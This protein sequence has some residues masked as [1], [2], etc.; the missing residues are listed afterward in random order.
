MEQNSNMHNSTG[1]TSDKL[2]EQTLKADGNKPVSGHTENANQ[3]DNDEATDENQASASK[4][5][6][7]GDKTSAS[8]YT[9][10]N[11]SNTTRANEATDKNDSGSGGLGAGGG[12]SAGEKM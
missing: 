2:N 9:D 10:K 12:H 5:A 1:E 3:D 11:R 4:H 6:I 7:D 8:T